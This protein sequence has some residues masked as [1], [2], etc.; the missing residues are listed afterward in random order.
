MST[1]ETAP[2]GICAVWAAHVTWKVQRGA[3]L[4]QRWAE[5]HEIKT[6]LLDSELLGLETG[7]VIEVVRGE[8]KTSP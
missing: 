6:A 3:I 2:D 7:T 1:V 4:V 8:I 5:N